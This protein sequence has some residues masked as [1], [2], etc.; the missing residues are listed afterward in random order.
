MAILHWLL[1]GSFTLASD[2]G[3]APLHDASPYALEGQLQIEAPERTVGRFS[4][5]AQLLP[6][7]VPAEEEGGPFVLSAKLQSKGAAACP[8]GDDLFANGFETP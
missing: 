3:N 8:A 6:A 7:G 5:R 1:A 2:A 4:L